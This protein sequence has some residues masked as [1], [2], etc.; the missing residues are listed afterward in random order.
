[1]IMTRQLEPGVVYHITHR[2]NNRMPIFLTDQDRAVYLKYMEEAL[3]ERSFKVH[4]YCLMG[5]HVHLL[6]SADDPVDIPVVL[7]LLQGRYGR[8]FNQTWHRSGSVWH[9]RYRS[10]RIESDAH[11]IRSFMYLD[12]NPVR[13][14]MVARPEDWEWS[15]YRSLAL[16]HSSPLLTLH[17][18]YLELG[19]DSSGRCRT[20]GLRMEQFLAEWLA[21]PAVE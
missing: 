19:A 13:K 14:R 5:N 18:S 20:Y 12:M 2:G 7:Q 21:L 11:L 16:G 15:S 1:M 17:D 4:C 6:V 9:R 3:V 8:Y 10:K